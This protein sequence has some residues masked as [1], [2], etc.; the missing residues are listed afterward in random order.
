M[1][2]FSSF[3]FPSRRSIFFYP[4]KNLN[5]KSFRYLKRAQKGRQVWQWTA[6]DYTCSRPCALELW[7]AHLSSLQRMVPVFGE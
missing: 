2:L 6:I 3:V 1:H 7:Q 5:S 4:Q